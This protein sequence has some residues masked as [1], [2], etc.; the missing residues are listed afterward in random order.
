[1]GSD[2]SA[3][4]VFPSKAP[5][6]LGVLERQGKSVRFVASPGITVTSD[7]KAVQNLLLAS[8]ASAKPTK[9]EVGT[10]SF[11]VIE[12]G[13]R[14]GIRLRDSEAATRKNFLGI[15]RFPVQASYAVVATLKPHDKTI[16]VPNVLGDIEDS[17]S[18]CALEFQLDGKSY[19]LDAVDDGGDELFL[20]FG[21]KTNGKETYGPG[22]FL[23][24]KKPDGSGKTT[25]DFNKAYNPPCAF[26]P[27]ATCPLPPPQNKLPVAVRAG[28]K[29][30]AGSV[31]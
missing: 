7:G 21:D 3:K 25:L 12:R 4:V 18:P 11:F 30:Y 14:V 16:A 26:T 20:I 15:E 27:F 1:V 13:E 6:S 23:Y 24:V 22:R 19:A 10:L 9:L 8:D 31:H 17:K 29:K 5:R 2:P 28:E